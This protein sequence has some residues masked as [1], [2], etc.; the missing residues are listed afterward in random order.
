M[1]ILYHAH[2]FDGFGAAWAAWLKL[3]DTA[4]YIPVL[5]GDSPP[6]GL[7]GEDVVIVDF[8]YPRVV[9]EDLHD[10][11]ASLLVKDHHRTAET[12]LAG[13]DY[14]TFDMEKSGA[15]LAWEHFCPDDS[16]APLIMY[17]QDRDLWQ[18]RLPFSREIAA[19]MRSWPMDFEQ[20][21]HANLQ[22]ELELQKVVSEGKAILRFQSR[23]VEQMCEQAVWMELGGYRVPVANAT[24]FFSEV[25]EKLCEMYQE[26]PFAAYY[27]D[28]A[29]GK[30]Q[31]GLRSKGGFDV[32]EVAKQFGGGGHSAAA[33]FTTEQGKRPHKEA[34]PEPPPATPDTFS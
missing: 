4:E 23:C 26:A 34:P 2:C 16:P 30:Q 5:Y 18:F 28:R 20:W 9:L 7:D 22:L 17:V 8:S 21:N 1:K 12:D 15:M 19:W 24:L 13:L 29:D 33:G 10:R 6:S 3:G 31:W 11:C 14:C 27:F 32:S 25:G